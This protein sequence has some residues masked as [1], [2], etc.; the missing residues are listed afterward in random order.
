MESIKKNAA[1]RIRQH[2]WLI[3]FHQIFLGAKS[4]LELASQGDLMDKKFGIRER[5]LELAISTCYNL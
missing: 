4:P 1:K 2:A 5:Q 3:L